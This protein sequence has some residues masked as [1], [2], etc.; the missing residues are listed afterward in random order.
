MYENLEYT[1]SAELCERMAAECD[2]AILS[3][4]CGKDSVAAWLQMRKYFK[5]I[6]PVFMY[7]VP[8]LKFIEQS[9]TYYEDF[10]QTH[11]Y[12][13]PHP[14]LLD[15]LNSC[16]MIPPDQIDG[17]LRLYGGDLEGY[18]NK[19]DVI[20][21]VRYCKGLPDSVYCATGIRIA[22]N[23]SRRMNIAVSGAVNHN[24][25]SFYP[26]YDWLK[27][28]MLKAFHESGVKLAVDYR[29]W[30][31][32]FDGLMYEYLDGMRTLLPD[33]YNTLLRWFPLADTEFLRYG[34]PEKARI[35]R[36]VTEE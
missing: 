27:A 29:I 30:G 17:V 21:L 2:T 20:D 16:M 26:I 5:T 28:D 35:K 19:R 24:K 15:W 33:D 9:L 12:R 6:I 11:I 4:S 3:F 10:F 32:S 25:Q 36:E 18:K 8:K 14:C 23:L 13:L 7:C 34:E 31:R 1:N 22:D